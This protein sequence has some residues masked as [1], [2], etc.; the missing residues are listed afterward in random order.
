MKKLISGIKR[1]LGLGP[2]PDE[3]EPIKSLV[4]LIKEPRNINLDTVLVLARRVLGPDMEDALEVPDRPDLPGHMYMIIGNNPPAGYGVIFAHRPYVDDVEE[5]ASQISELRLRSLFS[6]HQAW[7][8]VDIMGNMD[9]LKSWQI[10][11]KLLAELAGPDCLALYSPTTERMVPY[12]EEL[13][14]DLRSTDP[15]AAFANLGYSPVVSGKDVEEELQQTVQEART[16]WADFV[17]AF[18][19]QEP[20]S[21]DFAV[22]FAFETPDGGNEYLWVKVQSLGEEIVT[23]T[24]SNEPLYIPTLKFGSYVEKPV[25]ELQDW[26]YSKSGDL[27]GCFSAKVLARQIR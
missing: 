16:A 17:K 5:V 14:D 21:D 1:L 15:K 19:A 20:G 10:I 26:M 11:G 9:T 8:A 3:N 6:E 18:E 27:V 24:I 13:L 22:K 4:W 7:I 23:G 25:S 2:K 12:T